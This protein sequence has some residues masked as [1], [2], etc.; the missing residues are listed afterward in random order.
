[1]VRLLDSADLDP[2][3]R[4][5]SSART[6][7]VA[8]WDRV[9]DRIFSSGLAVAIVLRGDV[10]DDVR[11]RLGGVVDELDLAVSEIRDMAL[12]LAI[13]DR[14]GRPE[15]ISEA[16][17]GPLVVADAQPDGD[18]HSRR[19]LRRI[20]ETEMFAYAAR[21]TGFFRA[22]DRTLWAHE[23]DGLLLSARSGAPLAHRV[24]NIFYDVESDRPL[25]IEDTH[26]VLAPEGTLG[27]RVE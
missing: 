8:A 20:A 1:M 12:Q 16:I 27:G 3:P 7:Q 19:R 17:V 25:Y 6:A 9:L 26:A 24:G 4:L 2:S 15:E 5:D 10:D 14:V 13:L 22:S 23:H 11:D 21:G 18:G